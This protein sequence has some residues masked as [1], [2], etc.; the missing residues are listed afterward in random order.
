M[1]AF[2]GAGGKMSAQSKEALRAQLVGRV[3]MGTAWKIWHARAMHLQGWHEA[4][5]IPTITRR[6][7]RRAAMQLGTSQRE[8]QHPVHLARACMHVRS[9]AQHLL[10]CA[11]VH[12]HATSGCNYRACT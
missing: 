10:K 7:R 9:C 4:S 11:V 8:V 12:A 5:A 2:E 3:V 1:Q 6:L